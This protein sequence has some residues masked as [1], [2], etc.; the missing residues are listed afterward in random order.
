MPMK[1][2]RFWVG[3]LSVMMIMLF[4]GDSVAQDRR[5]SKSQRRRRWPWKGPEIGTVIQDFELPIL[6]GGKF[7]LSDH[8]GKIIIIELGACT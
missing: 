2:Y 1:K 8:R 4:I 6:N 3:L 5:K 7:K